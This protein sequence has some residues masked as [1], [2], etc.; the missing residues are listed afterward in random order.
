MCTILIT[1]ALIIATIII[2]NRKSLKYI[3][4]NRKKEKLEKFFCLHN[5]REKIKVY[6]KRETKAIFYCEKLVSIYYSKLLI[7]N[8]EYDLDIKKPIEIP[9][10]KKNP[11]K[12]DFTEKIILKSINGETKEFIINICYYMNNYYQVLLDNIE[13]PITSEIVFYSK[14]QAFP[15]TFKGTNIIFKEYDNNNIPLLKRYNI[16]NINRNELYEIY[17]KYAF[18]KL[19]DE[20]KFLLEKFNSLFINFIDK[21]DQN[22][23]EGK[24]Y[25]QEEDEIIEDFNEKEN[26][27]LERTFQFLNDNNIRIIPAYLILSLFLAYIKKEDITIAQGIINKISN[28]N[29]FIKYLNDIPDKKMIENTE[30]A[31]FIESI[32][33]KAYGIG[34]YQNYLEYKKNIIKNENEFNNFEKLVI[35]VNIYDLLSKHQDFKLIR[36]YDLPIFSPFFES[37]KI[38]LDIIKQINENSY[39]YF[40]YLQIISS[41]GFDNISLNTWYKIKYIPLIEIKAHLLYCRYNFF[42]LYNSP[43]DVPAFVN[44]Q[45]LIKSFNSCKKCGFIYINNLETE[46]NINNTAK[47]LIY[48]FHENCHSKLDFQNHKSLSP[49]YLYNYDLKALDSHYDTI[50]AYIL[51]KE[52]PSSNKKGED[53]G[54]EGYSIELFLYND[55]SITDI[56]MESND[57]LEKLCNAELYSGNNFQELNEILT[58]IIKDKVKNVKI[59]NNEVKKLNLCNKKTQENN[60]QK[61]NRIYYFRNG[62]IEDRY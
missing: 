22:K 43:L 25:E 45:T 10:D 36:L 9:I 60:N 16:I 49:R 34:L 26:E 18:N 54:E 8:S 50:I 33:K 38:Y 11:I 58:N 55:Y 31:L 37:K 62:I 14:K 59:H 29:Y 44:P 4:I 13:D 46:K 41:Y 27:L 40:F 7:F 52:L 35:M 3:Y 19:K 2:V 12:S 42:F 5:L 23:Y 15:E 57:N 1:I 56:I 51:G 17:N 47:L 30:S 21:I 20:N 24:I 48:K 6:E 53:S 32:S 39:L 61:K 28:K